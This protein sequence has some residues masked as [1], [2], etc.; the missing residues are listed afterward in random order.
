MRLWPCRG[1]ERFQVQA[2]VER[3]TDFCWWCAHWS[4][5]VAALCRVALGS[6]YKVFCENDLD[7]FEGDADALALDDDIDGG[8][9]QF[10]DIGA[11]HGFRAAEA[12]LI[13]HRDAIGGRPVK[14][15]I[16]AMN[17]DGTGCGH[18][19]VELLVPADGAEIRHR[20]WFWIAIH[21]RAIKNR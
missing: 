18:E 9:N 7:D 14:S 8:M 21:L 4:C 13:R 10:A 12:A 2:F 1:G 17:D 19:G 6:A 11:G 16:T 20:C 3:G 5:A 15:A